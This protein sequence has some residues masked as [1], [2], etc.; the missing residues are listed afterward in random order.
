M[1]LDRIIWLQLCHQ[2]YY[3]TVA[4]STLYEMF[5]YIDTASKWTGKSNRE[6]QIQIHF[7]ICHLGLH[8]IGKIKQLQT[9]QL[10]LV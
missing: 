6:T 3:N 5:K 8:V 1:V 9:L 7:Q 4:T 10:K 2:K